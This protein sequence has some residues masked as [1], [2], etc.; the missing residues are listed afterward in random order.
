MRPFAPNVA[1]P[2]W[3]RIDHEDWAALAAVAWER[4]RRDW[5]SAGDTDR[6]YLAA[7]RLAP[8]PR[9]YLPRA[10]STTAA[11]LASQAPLAG[12]TYLAEA[13]GR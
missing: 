10:P 9:T 6:A 13:L 11:R 4:C 2:A 7:R 8:D 12:P 5:E 3:H 1:R